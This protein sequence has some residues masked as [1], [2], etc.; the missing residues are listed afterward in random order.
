METISHGDVLL[1][2]VDDK[3]SGTPPDF[4]I[5]ESATVAVQ[6]D[7][8]IVDGADIYYGSDA[9]MAL[10]GDFVNLGLGGYAADFGWLDG[11]VAFNASGG[12]GVGAPVQTVEA[13]GENRGACQTGMVDNFAFGTLILGE[14]AVVEVV[15]TFDNQEDGIT[16]CD[17]ALYVGMLTV[18]VGAVLNTNGCRVYYE[19]LENEGTIPELGVDVLP[20]PVADING[21]CEVGATDLSQ[22]LGAWGPCEICEDCPADV[23]GDCEVGGADLAAVLGA[24]GPND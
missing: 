3:G 16:A 6:G 4:N 5:T 15:D 2:H 19:H 8:I 11:G 20:I 18:G 14:G 23:N 9:P 22:L 21:D 1:K 7:F 24:W 17:E 13:A 10:D 12:A